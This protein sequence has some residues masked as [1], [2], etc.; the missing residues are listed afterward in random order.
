MDLIRFLKD[1]KLPRF[2]FKVG[3]TWELPQSRYQPDRSAELG[4][5]QVPA[6]SFVIEVE[7]HTRAC[8]CPC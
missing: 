1:V 5:G 7:D 4:G 8:G 2:S 6:G 3:E